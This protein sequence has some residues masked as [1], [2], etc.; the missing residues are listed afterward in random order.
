[1]K[2]PLYWTIFVLEYGQKRKGVMAVYSMRN[3]FGHIQVYDQKGNFLFS[4]DNEREA[5]E[6]L[7]EHAE[8]AA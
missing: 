7:E 4:A 5:W 6:E 3:V 2:S 8:S 1:M